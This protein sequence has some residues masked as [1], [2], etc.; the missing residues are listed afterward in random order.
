ME[1]IALVLVSLALMF[2]LWADVR[3]LRSISARLRAIESAPQELLE[4]FDP[5][6]LVERIDRLTIAVAEG[7]SH[8]DRAERR[9]ETTLRSAKKKLAEVDL[10]DHRIEAEIAGLHT[11]DGSGSEGGQLQLVPEDVEETP[12]ND[13]PSGVPGLTLSQLNDIRAAR[14]AEA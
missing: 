12:W 5:T 4:P 14:A 6:L 9:V 7:I 13:A 8:V 3:V 10:E 1:T 2:S 11:V